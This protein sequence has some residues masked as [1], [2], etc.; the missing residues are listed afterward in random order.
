MRR[1]DDGR[2]RGRNA[3]GAGEGR[4]RER[5]RTVLVVRPADR[6]PSRFLAGDRSRVV[7][8]L[9]PLRT[10]LPE[11][12]G[13]SLAHARVAEGE[14]TL[15]HRLAGMVEVY[16]VLEGRGLLEVE[17]DRVLLERGDAALIPPGAC[18]RV[19]SLGP[20]DLA[21]LCV[22]SPPW[23]AEGERVFGAEE[24][25]PGEEESQ[26]DTDASPPRAWAGAPIRGSARRDG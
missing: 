23:R 7:E 8:I 19:Q 10:A 6:E 16:Y 26:G 17:G 14:W 1:E 18:Q 12:M 13:F 25:A 5:E 20:G 21:F 4:A 2:S 24:R 11:A 15:P 9:H 22:V 3:E